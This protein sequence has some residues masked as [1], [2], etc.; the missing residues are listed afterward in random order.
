M[1]ETDPVINNG[2]S[3]LIQYSANSPNVTSKIIQKNTILIMLFIFQ[4]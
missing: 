3:R 4:V 1:N 2:T